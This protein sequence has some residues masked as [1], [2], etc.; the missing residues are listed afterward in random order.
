[1]RL[2][3]RRWVTLGYQRARRSSACRAYHVARLIPAV[4]HGFCAS[5]VLCRSSTRG[6]PELRE[7]PEFALPLCCPSGVARGAMRSIVAA[8]VDLDIEGSAP[9]AADPDR[10]DA[11]AIG[12]RH[13]ASLA[14]LSA[15]SLGPSFAI[16]LFLDY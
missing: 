13:L 14:C 7:C 2:S 9:A 11:L 6:L 3:A 15:S 8:S 1:M 5:T 4:T 10:D 12:L 16:R